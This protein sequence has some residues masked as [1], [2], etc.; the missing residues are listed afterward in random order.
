LDCTIP[1]EW[2]EKPLPIT[3]D[4]DI[5]KRVEARWAELGL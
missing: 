5:V 4:D 1:F 3:L 2:K